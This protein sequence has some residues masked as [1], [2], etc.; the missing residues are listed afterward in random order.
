M[1]NHNLDNILTNYQP[2]GGYITS[3][4]DYIGTS[5]KINQEGIFSEIIF[6]PVKSYSCACGRYNYRALYENKVCPDCG[7]ICGNN[8]LRSEIFGKIK[9]IFPV[10]K[11]NRIKNFVK[12]FGINIKKIFNT[13]RTD[14]LISM[15]NYI[16]INDNDVKLFNKLEAD[17]NFLIIPLRITGIYSFVFVLKFINDNFKLLKIKEIFDKNY[18]IDV[19]KVF[20]PALRNTTYDARKKEHRTPIIN[21]YYTA[22]LQ[23]NKNQGNILQ[24]LDLDQKDLTDKLKYNIKNKILNQEILEPQIIEYDISTARYQYYINL[25]YQY[26]YDELSGKEGL[27]R[28][29]ILSKNIDFSGRSI[30][31][32]DP[33][34][35][36][37][38][39]KV[40]KI[41]LKK[42]WLPYFL[43]YLIYYEN[44]S[45]DVAYNDYIFNSENQEYNEKFDRFLNWFCN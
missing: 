3:P 29:N 28:S 44:I 12:I 5:R 38:K 42:L 2:L 41:L 4:V 23:M 21:K 14:T 33:S 13:I 8:N 10:I 32:I 40:G 1:Q 18:I 15:T 16:G 45:P 7:V 39:I 19:L 43:H 37:Y 30:I 34:L 35:C 36:P 24:T 9:L 27:I 11:F 17:N 31:T 22:I 25:I 6:G 26:V 20:P